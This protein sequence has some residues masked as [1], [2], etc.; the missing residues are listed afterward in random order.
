MRTRDVI[1]KRGQSLDPV[2]GPSPWTYSQDPVAELSRWTQSQDP[3]AGLSR[4]TQSQD[5]V[6]GPRR[7]T[8]SLD[9][10]AGPI[11]WTHSQDPVAG[12]SISTFH[13]LVGRHLYNVTFT[14]T[15]KLIADHV[16][17]KHRN[18]QRQYTTLSLGHEFQRF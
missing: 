3:V 1:L 15:A 18:C 12:P 4:R 2:A 16:L 5:P 6:T 7:W 8:Q 17:D 10:V 11:C 9:P 13:L 14:L